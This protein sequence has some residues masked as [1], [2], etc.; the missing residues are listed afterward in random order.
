M[1]SSDNNNSSKLKSECPEGE[2]LVL[3]ISFAISSPTALLYS[4]LQCDTTG[5]ED[6]GL[7][8]SATL[9]LVSCIPIDVLA[10]DWLARNRRWKRTGG[11]LAMA[12]E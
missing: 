4:S 7:Q 9:S 11:G 1:T 10:V 5:D 2:S 3:R 6:L 8:M 12:A